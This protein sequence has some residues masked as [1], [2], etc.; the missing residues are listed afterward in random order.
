MKEVKGDFWEWAREFKPDAIVCTTNKI[1][2]TNGRLVMGAGIAKDFRDKYEDVDLEWGKMLK[3]NSRLTL[4]VSMSCQFTGGHHT[5]MYLISFP[6][7]YHW[8]DDSSL[9][10]ISI[11]ARQLKLFTDITGCSKVLMVRPGC[12]LGGLVWESVKFILYQVPLDDRF[13]VIDKG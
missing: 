9:S 1:V 5:P 12:G 13:T 4:M 8:N 2:K 10:M 11:A 6:T 7:K 3:R